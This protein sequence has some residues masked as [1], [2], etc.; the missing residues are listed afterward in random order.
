MAGDLIAE[1]LAF[2]DLVERYD[3]AVER[4]ARAGYAGLKSIAA[5][6]SGLAIRRWSAEEAPRRSRA[7]APPA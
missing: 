1:G 4:R 2:A 6:R 3:A 5:Y 7:S